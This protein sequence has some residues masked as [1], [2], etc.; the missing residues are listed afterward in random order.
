MTAAGPSARSLLSVILTEY[1]LPG[2]G[3]VQTSALLEGMG[4]LDVTEASARQSIRRLAHDGIIERDGPGQWRLTEVGRKRLVG[5]R[6][7]QVALTNRDPVPWDGQWLLVRTTVPETQ[8]GLRHEL[9]RDLVARGFG[10][11]GQGWFIIADLGAE[12]LA[13]EVLARLT[14]RRPRSPSLLG[15]ARW[16]R[17]TRSWSRHGTSKRCASGTSR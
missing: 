2:S 13:Q 1:V 15:L 17:R 12:A 4:A 7:R 16:A 3:T 8:R 10:T 9:R 6:S 11:L 5:L 14:S